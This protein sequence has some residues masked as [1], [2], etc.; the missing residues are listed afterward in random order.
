MKRIILAFVAVV[1]ALGVSAQDLRWGA[2]GALN[3]SWERAKI[4]SATISSDSYIGFQAGIKA[5]MDLSS[6]L[7]D[8]FFADGALVYNL[9][10]GSY[11]GSSHTNLGFLQL[12]V[13]IGYRAPLSGSI[14]FIGSLGPYFGLGVLGKD[15]VKEGGSKI[16]SDLFG[17]ELQRFDFGLNYRLGVE[18]WEQW[19]FYLGFEHSL[20]NLAKKDKTLGDNVKYRLVNFY[21]G[22][23]FMF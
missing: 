18:V 23:A 10:G 5:E 3:F 2:V 16:K 14:N 8:G 13:N 9:K 22:T 15:V 11:S 20:L 7:A 12:P 6:Y 17:E 1:S 4:A 19:Q 21:I